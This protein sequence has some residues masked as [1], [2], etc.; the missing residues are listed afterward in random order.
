MKVTC[1]ASSFADPADIRRFRKCK[2]EGKSDKQ[3][4]KVGDNGIGFWGDDVS[5]GTGSACA[6]PP[7]VIELNGLRHNYP[8]IVSRNER[9]T[10]ALLKDHMP[11]LRNLAND[12]RID[13]NPDACRELGLVPPVMTEVTYEI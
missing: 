6:L 2:A 9:K 12:A 10:I 8:V 3:C 13:L 11:H 7:E 5:E 4:F 1:Y